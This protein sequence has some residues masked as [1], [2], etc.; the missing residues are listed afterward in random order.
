MRR[1]FPDVQITIRPHAYA[2]G[3]VAPPAA[4]SAATPARRTPDGSPSSGPSSLNKGST[5]L[6]ETAMA[7]R[8]LGLP[9]EF[10]VVGFTDRDPALLRLGNVYHHRPLSRGPGWR[11]LLA[12]DATLA[13]FPA[14]WPET[15]SYT[16]PWRWRRRSSR[17]CSISARP[18]IG[19]S[20]W[21][22]A[23]S[24]HRWPPCWTLPGTPGCC[25]VRRCP[26]P[27][28]DLLGTA[29]KARR[30]RRTRCR[31]TISWA[32]IERL[33][34]RHASAGGDAVAGAA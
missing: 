15:P 3:A 12:A 34:A 23:R 10:V 27:P 26:G 29:S 21:A 4:A 18:P 14:V 19:S 20:V 16:Y 32:A 17:S 9:L 11:A 8:D 22:G 25:C 13:W 30:L 5:L 1:H 7:A 28:A 6:F 33:G 31:P 2:P 24:W